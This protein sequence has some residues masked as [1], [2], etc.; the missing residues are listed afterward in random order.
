MNILDKKPQL[1]PKHQ[2][3][4]GE[5][6]IQI[7]YNGPQYYEIVEQM[8][9]EDPDTYNQLQIETARK[10]NPNSEI[11]MYIDSDGNIRHATNIGAGF[12]SGTDP[13][14]AELVTGVA[15]GKPLELVG[16]TALLG[17]GRAG[18]N[19][20]RAKLIS[21]EMKNVSTPTYTYPLNVGWGPKQTIKVT[22]ATDSED[23]LQLFFDQ[24]WDVTNEGANPFG[25]WYQGKWGQPRTAATNSLPGKAEKAAK[26]RK[27]FE[28]R[29]YKHEGTL[30]LK[31]PMVTVG[32]VPSRSALSYDAEKMGADGIIY[33]NVYDNGF[34][35]NQVILSQKLHRPLIQMPQRKIVLN[36]PKTGALVFRGGNSTP[37][38]DFPYYYTTDP[39]YAA[40]YGKVKMGV[41]DVT[42][43]VPSRQ[44]FINDDPISVDMNFALSSEPYKVS[45]LILKGKDKVTWEFEPS[46]GI[47]YSTYEPKFTELNIQK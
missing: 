32:E 43:V 31:K 42:D 45:N 33:N 27:I 29:K 36:R 4:S 20:A 41:L 13:I 7:K 26:A 8:K 16:K 46:R 44:P 23:P 3:G 40:H 9:K 38:G 18:N 37:Y 11:V 19:W 24:R 14:G 25:V 28:D 5:K 15:L 21:R 1:V 35:N 22:H 10:Q 39:R 34:D 17:L 12:V 6:G 30:T 47:E 2:K